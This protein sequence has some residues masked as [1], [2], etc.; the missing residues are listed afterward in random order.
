MA[1][2]EAELFFG[3]TLSANDIPHVAT[4]VVTAKTAEVALEMLRKLHEAG[5]I[6]R[7]NRELAAM[8]ETETG[9]TEAQ[10]RELTHQ[11]DALVASSRRQFA[12]CRHGAHRMLQVARRGALSKALFRELARLLGDTLKKHDTA[13]ECE[14]VRSAAVQL[15]KAA[16]CMKNRAFNV[17]QSSKVALSV[18]APKQ[19]A[20]VGGSGA[21]A[22]G[23]LAWAALTEGCCG[24][25]GTI[26]LSGVAL[27]GLP[28]WGA[29]AAVAAVF[30]LLAFGGIK[31]YEWWSNKKLQEHAKR[32]ERLVKELET[33]QLALIQLGE[34]ANRHKLKA[35]KLSEHVQSLDN[36]AS[37]G[38]LLSD[39][40]FQMLAPQ[41]L[42]E[43]IGTV[44]RLEQE[45]FSPAEENSGGEVYVAGVAGFAG[46][47]SA[48]LVLATSSCCGEA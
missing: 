19:A 21:V 34:D 45:T 15:S 16:E 39:E 43:F 37:V 35:D 26:A 32:F 33:L 27:A 24:A 4:S 44:S 47:V 8:L 17:Q 1:T 46:G 41:M 42:E 13:R 38:E 10:L 29:I 7:D 20:I 6:L 28:L 18:S 40:T 9:M 48:G 5:K 23:T 22:A 31:A 30:S 14:K 2:K 25:A 3:S 11:L 36:D 12:F